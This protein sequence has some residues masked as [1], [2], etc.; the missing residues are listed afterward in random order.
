MSA[1]TDALAMRP[2]MTLQDLCEYFKANLVP[3]NPETMAEYIVAGRFPFAVGLDPPQQGRGQRK[4]LISRAGAY[5]WLDA[6]LQTE[7]IK[8]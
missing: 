7:T 6:F 8:I 3:A 5:A 4:L 1:S 2:T